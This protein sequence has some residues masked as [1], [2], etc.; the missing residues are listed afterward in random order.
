MRYANRQRPP[1]SYALHNS[2]DQKTIV[3]TLQQTKSH[4]NLP[5]ILP[6]LLVAATA[7]QAEQAPINKQTAIAFGPSFRAAVS[8]TA[9]SLSS[10]LLPGSRIEKTIQLMAVPTN[11]GSVVYRFMMP[12]YFP[13]D[14]PVDEVDVDESS[15]PCVRLRGTGAS[16]SREERPR[17][18]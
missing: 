10:G 18:W 15:R 16:S 6:N 9:P 3:A 11:C 7:T 14:S 8:A 12:R 5:C 1:F 17:W 2:K 4:H 13:E